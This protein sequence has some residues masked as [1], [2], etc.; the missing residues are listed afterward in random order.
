[1]PG[2]HPVPGKSTKT[3]TDDPYQIIENTYFFAPAPDT[4]KNMEILK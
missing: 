4:L 1:M 2:Q 3:M